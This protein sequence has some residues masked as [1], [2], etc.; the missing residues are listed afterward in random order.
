MFEEMSR[1]NLVLIVIFVMPEKSVSNGSNFGLVSFGM[2]KICSSI[3]NNRAL[4]Q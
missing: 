4:A 1:I 2:E 3:H